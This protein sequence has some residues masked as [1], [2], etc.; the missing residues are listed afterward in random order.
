MLFGNKYAMTDGLFI[1]CITLDWEF[2]G[3]PGQGIKNQEERTQELK[4]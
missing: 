2:Y 3:I 1:A 4:N